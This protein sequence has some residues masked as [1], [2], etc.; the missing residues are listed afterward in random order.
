MEVQVRPYEPCDLPAMARIWNRVVTDGEAFPQLDTVSDE[1]A[2]DY[3]GS[4]SCCGV[5]EI[6]G[7]VV[8]MYEVRPNNIG[9]CGHIGNASYAVDPDFR[10]MHVGRALVSDSLARA[11]ELGFRLM[12]FNAVVRENHNAIHLYESL[13]FVRVGIIPGGFRHI[14]GEYHDII[15]FYHELRW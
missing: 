12:Q 3:F 2:T 7:R 4:F 6:D 1:E 14:D 10:G 13:G 8:G 5:A 11:R 9:R 15:I